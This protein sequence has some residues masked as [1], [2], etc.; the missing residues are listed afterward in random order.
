MKSLLVFGQF[1][2][3]CLRDSLQVH[4]FT[5]AFSPDGRFT[6]EAAYLERYPGRLANLLG[7]D[8]YAD[9]GRNGK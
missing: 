7:I 4:N 3:T 9:F 6:R 5:Y 2:V 1:T 8:D